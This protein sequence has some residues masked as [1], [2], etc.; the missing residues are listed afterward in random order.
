MTLG[1]GLIILGFFGGAAYA[2]TRKPREREARDQ[3][4]LEAK[5]EASRSPLYRVRVF[6]DPR[7]QQ[8]VKNLNKSGGTPFSS[9]AFLADVLREKLAKIG[10]TGILLAT[11]DPT[12]TDLWTFLARNPREQ[13]WRG[14]QSQGFRIIDVEPVREPIVPAHEQSSSALDKGL[15]IAEVEA[16][17]HA[18]AHDNDEKHLGGFASTLEPEYPLS[19]AL[20][21]AK[22]KLAA[23]RSYGLGV[24][25]SGSARES[26]TPTGI[27]NAAC[28]KNV[29]ETLRSK[30][31]PLGQ[32]VVRMWNRY[33]PVLSAMSAKHCSMLTER[34]RGLTESAEAPKPVPA[35]AIQLAYASKRPELSRVQNRKKIGRKLSVISKAADAG[36]PMAQTAQGSVTRA[37]KLLER[38]G[39]VDWFRRIESVKMTE[40]GPPPGSL[41]R[42]SEH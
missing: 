41:T 21:Y 26:K 37:E 33:E 8:L 13:A 32:E 9:Q 17:T 35:S 34:L 12:N 3:A 38:R 19:A 1:L 2:L 14:T 28:S 15:S 42:R 27:V 11:N 10:F 7:Y 36:L 31:A 6:V 20:L 16:I 29:L 5:G 25:P 4:P 24:E 30:S 40:K 22:A 18:L 39:W 23:A